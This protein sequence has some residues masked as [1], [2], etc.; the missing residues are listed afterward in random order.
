MSLGANIR[1]RYLQRLASESRISLRMIANSASPRL[2]LCC[3]RLS[4]R[5]N[6]PA[7]SIFLRWPLTFRP[8]SVQAASSSSVKSNFDNSDARCCGPEI[9]GFV[10]SLW[11]F[12]SVAAETWWLLMSAKGGR[13]G[14]LALG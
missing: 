8:V 13:V 4:I 9:H 2:H 12:A 11:I 6:L 14:K 1:L 3:T 5:H 10:S 7:S